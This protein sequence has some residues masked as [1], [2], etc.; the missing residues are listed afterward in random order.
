MPAP[1]RL[2]IT[3][4][5]DVVTAADRNIHKTRWE[6]AA[7]AAIEAA[8]QALADRLTDEDVSLHV[9]PYYEWKYNWSETRPPA[10]TWGV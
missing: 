9:Q 1:R 8:S 10:S 2:R 4:D 3:L 7:Q 6:P 5:V